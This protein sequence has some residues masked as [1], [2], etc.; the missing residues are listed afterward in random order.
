MSYNFP[1]AAVNRYRGIL[2]SGELLWVYEFIHTFVYRD[3]MFCVTVL[4]FNNTVSNS[5][6]H[7]TSRHWVTVVHFILGLNS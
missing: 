3:I 2:Q 4:D 6:K 1:P 7:F 5:N